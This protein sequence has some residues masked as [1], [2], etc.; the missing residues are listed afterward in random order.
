MRVMAQL[1]M[2]MNPG[3]CIGCH[4]CSVTCKQAS[5]N[6][7][8]LEYAWFNNVETRPGLGYAPAGQHT[9]VARPISQIDGRPMKI[10]WSANWDDDLGG[11]PE[12]APG[13][14]LL[15][16]ISRQ[17]T[18]TRYADAL[19]AL[20]DP[21]LSKRPVTI[22]GR[23][24]PGSP[25]S[26]LFSHMLNIDPPDHERL[27][28][29]DDGGDRLSRDEMLAMAFLLLAAGHETPPTS[30]PAA[31]WPCRCT[32]ASGPGSGPTHPWSPARCRNCSATSARPCMRRC[33]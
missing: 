23:Q 15:A 31:C 19:A 20:A 25:E 28:H 18:I 26:V 12:H 6:R 24:R 11:G 1:V 9:P 32:S 10:E 8:D 29:A 21:R 7:A 33:G 16:R 4:I 22:R 30:S 5:T 14:P 13:D 27:I 3:K 2:V 17:V